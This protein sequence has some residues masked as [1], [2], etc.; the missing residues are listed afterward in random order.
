MKFTFK[1]FF[2]I[3]AVIAVTLGAGGFYLLN[4]IFNSSLERETMQAA[5]DINIL[6]FAFE[7]TVMNV[8]NKY[9]DLQDKTVEEIVSVL[10]TGRHIRVSTADK[11][12]LNAFEG[13]DADSAL[14]DFV[15]DT[16]QPHRIIKSQG[17]YYINTAACVNMLGRVLYIETFKDITFVFDDRDTGFGIYRNIILLTL[18]CGT[19]VIYL[20]SLW[21]TKPIRLLSRSVKHMAA[22]DY[23]IRAE[24]TGNDELGML[25]NDFNT[26]AQA[27]ESNINEINENSHSHE[28]FIASFAHEL[29]TPLTSIVGYADLLRSRNL[30]EEN[31]FM[32]ANY[33]HTEGKRLENL[34]IR[35]LDIIA[36]K[37]KKL[38]K[39]VTAVSSVF[40]VIKNT[41][42]P[43]GIKVDILYDDADID[44]ETDLI[45]TALVNLAENA[46]KAST[47]GDIIKIELKR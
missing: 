45:I 42:R 28:R 7:T 29:K 10:N 11:R 1:V 17:K 6:K 26:M 22:G 31:I 19:A 21:L 40:S 23:G 12:I 34:A 20:M 30:D 5:D 27:L 47:Q 13:L 25:T 4:S 16:V 37:N 43:V 18:I 44:I 38:D 32:S 39:R 24:Y 2:C 14:L 36:L 41:F 46:V 15:T 8:P 3:I 9:E 33:I 35:L